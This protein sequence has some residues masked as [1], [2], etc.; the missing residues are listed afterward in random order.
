MFTLGY[1]TKSLFFF[2][3][4]PKLNLWILNTMTASVMEEELL[5]FM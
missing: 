1:F 4:K 2:F 5:S 3:F